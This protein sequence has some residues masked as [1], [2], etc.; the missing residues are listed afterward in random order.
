MSELSTAQKC[1]IIYYYKTII[2]KHVVPIICKLKNKVWKYKDIDINNK[3]KIVFEIC[4][5]HLSNADYERFCE[6][7]NITTE[8]IVNYT[9]DIENVIFQMVL[10]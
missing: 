2:K 4:F 9:E 8:F 10:H 7:T 6:I 3:I 5:K 1:F